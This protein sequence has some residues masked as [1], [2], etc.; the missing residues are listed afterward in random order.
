[1]FHVTEE[2]RWCSMFREEDGIFSSKTFELQLTGLF[3][4]NTSSKNVEKLRNTLS[5]FVMEN[6]DQKVF[7]KDTKTT[8]TTRKTNWGQTRQQTFTFDKV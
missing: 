2:F 3:H 7:Y 5:K 4:P 1:M 8:T 6:L